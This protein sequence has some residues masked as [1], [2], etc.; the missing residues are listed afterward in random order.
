MFLLAMFIIFLELVPSRCF[1]IQSSQWY[2]SLSLNNLLCHYMW[3]T[4]NRGNQWVQYLKNL[5]PE[6]WLSQILS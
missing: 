4:M 2:P 3:N 1:P 5:I 6:S